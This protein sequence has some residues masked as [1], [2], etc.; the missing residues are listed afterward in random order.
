M[1]PDPSVKTRRSS[2]PSSQT[3]STS[4]VS[5][6]TSKKIFS[7]PIPKYQVQSKVGSR[8][9]IRHKPQGG[10]VKIH[11]EKPQWNA[12][13]KVPTKADARAKKTETSPP[14]AKRRITHNK[15]D[16]SK[17]TSR[18]GSLDNTRRSSHD[19]KTGSPDAATKAARRVSRHVIQNQKLDFSKVTS[20]VGS[21]DNIR[22]KPGGG[23]NKIFDEKPA[24]KAETKLPKPDK[25]TSLTRK[26][27]DVNIS[28]KPSSDKKL[29]EDA[30]EN[31]FLSEEPEEINE[32]PEQTTEQL[33]VA[34]P[35]NDTLL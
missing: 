20:K 32:A 30:G 8:D 7:Q 23:Q 10:T 34:A 28:N 18:V 33:T 31:P 27:A 11:D 17:V 14:D 3:S 4:G 21:K 22:H 16:L 6:T 26:L 29:E 2:T 1:S 5:S 25:M 12:Q 15:L 13:A 19:E 9:N 24:W 35:D